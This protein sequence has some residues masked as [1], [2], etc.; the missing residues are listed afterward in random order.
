MRNATVFNKSNLQS[1]LYQSDI[2]PKKI[3]MPEK[4]ADVININT[5]RQVA[6]ME[7]SKADKATSQ[8]LMMSMIKDRIGYVEKLYGLKIDT[9]S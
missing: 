8:A 5:L 1:A 9:N 7:H 4:K 6:G 3:N 2:A